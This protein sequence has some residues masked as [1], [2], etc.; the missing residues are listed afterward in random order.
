MNQHISRYYVCFL[1]ILGFKSRFEKFGLK[2]IASKY[3]QL[4]RIVDCANQRAEKLLGELNLRESPYWTQDGEFFIVHH[5]YGAYASDSI[6]LFAYADFPNNRHPQNVD[7]RK[8]DPGMQ[9]MYQTI[10]CDSFL[11]IINEIICHSIEIGLPLRGSLAIGEAILDLNRNVF[12]GKPLID[13]A[14][15]EKNQN[16]I[17]VGF[18]PLFSLEIIPERYKL[19]YTK[20]IKD[21]VPITCYAG[22]I[23]DW[24]RHWRKTRAGSLIQSVKQL[25]LPKEHERVTKEIIRAS[26]ERADFFETPEYTSFS[27]VYPQFSNKAELKLAVRCVQDINTKK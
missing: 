7:C 13:G 19:P 5:I 1:D 21:T 16:G 22:M 14:E 20:H 18:T 11:D 4:I 23:L 12:L 6:L 26:E 9:W 8:K 3:A 25:D 10:P 15:L 27:N 17:T 24:P 2:H